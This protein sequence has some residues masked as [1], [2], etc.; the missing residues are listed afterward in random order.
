MVS[1]LNIC[2]FKAFRGV[3]TSLTLRTFPSWLIIPDS[4]ITV[5]HGMPYHALAISCLPDLIDSL[6]VERGRR[7]NSAFVQKSIQY[8]N[9]LV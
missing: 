2:S 5:R 1:I 4:M 9:N 6:T 7:P 3:D 8:G